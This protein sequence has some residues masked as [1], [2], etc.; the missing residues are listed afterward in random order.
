[1]LGLQRCAG[2]A[3]ALALTSATKAWNLGGL[4]AA[5]AMA[6][7]EAGADLR[8]FKVSRVLF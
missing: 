1:M 6:G 5:L 8:R 7:P 3:A 2:I 4:K